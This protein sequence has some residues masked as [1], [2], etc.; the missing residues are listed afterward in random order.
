M[1]RFA[2]LCL[3]GAIF[4]QAHADEP[5]KLD[6]LVIEA[7]PLHSQSLELIAQPISILN[8]DELQ[9]KQTSTIGETLAL[10]PGVSASD[11]GQGASRPVIRGLGG[12]RLRIL[13]NSIGTLDVSSVSADH[14]VAVNPMLAEQIEVIRGPA[15]LLYGSGTTAGLVNIVNNRIPDSISRPEATF[16]TGLESAR[17]GPMAGLSIDVGHENKALHFDGFYQNLDDYEGAKGT[18][19]NSAMETRDVNLGGSFFMDEGYLGAAFGRYESVYEIPVDPQEAEEQPFID[20]EQNRYDFSSQLDRPFNGITKAIFRAA[21]NDYQHTEFESPGEP[22]TLFENNGF[23]GRLELTHDPV[24][25]FTGLFGLQYRSSDFISIGEEAFIGPSEQQSLGL[26]IYED[27]EISKFNLE[28]GVRYEYT[29]TEG[30][31]IRRN[32]QFKPNFNIYTLSAGATRNF[33]EDYRVGLYLTRAQRAPAIEELFSDGPHLASQ[34]YEEGDPGLDEETSNNIDLSLQKATGRW[35]W[36]INLFFNFIEDFVFLENLDEDGDGNADLVNGDR[37]LSAGDLQLV[38]YNQN[39]ANFYG[40]EFE[41]TINLLNEGSDKFDFRLFGDWV[42]GELTNGN[43]LPRISPAR[44]GIGLN[45]TKHNWQTYV[46]LV[47]VFDQKDVSLLETETDG[48]LL[49]NAG[50]SYNLSVPGGTLKIFLKANN[51]LD[52]DA[53][54][55]TSFI[56][57]R[58]PLPGRSFEAGLYLEM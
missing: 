21:Y 47:N 11:F 46:D 32:G 38:A 20:L 5:E 39:N 36:R 29:E 16:F 17:V 14:N 15:T 8:N 13:Q 33:N 45:H 24:N 56:K 2:S 52:E 55:H 25:N 26:F 12:P 34:T 23:E 44:L 22:G 35:Q 37:T 54:R 27:T 40:S 31:L 41:S 3:S 7:R 1:Q 19:Q 18:I 42:R 9:K 51:L 4:F 43:N 30:V 48:Y 50:Q 57:D 28:V 10:E 6:Q 49:L 58:A 53:R